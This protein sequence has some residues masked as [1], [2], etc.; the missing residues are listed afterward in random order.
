MQ[1]RNFSRALKKVFHSTAVNSPSSDTAKV[2]HSEKASSVY[3]RM[4]PIMQDNAV[5]G[6][7]A[8]L[9]VFLLTKTGK[10][11]FAMCQAFGL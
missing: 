11:L 3:V 2:Q 5:F 1:S 6:S 7:L 10:T 4:L 9:C 8:K